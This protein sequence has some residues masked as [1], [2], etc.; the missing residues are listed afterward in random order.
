MMKIDLGVR[1][2][3]IQRHY[4]RKSG[5]WRRSKEEEKVKSY[6]RCGISDFQ[7]NPSPA[8]NVAL[9]LSVLKKRGIK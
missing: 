9:G 5:Q 7:V 4:I 8:K 2:T 1:V 6:E 3:K